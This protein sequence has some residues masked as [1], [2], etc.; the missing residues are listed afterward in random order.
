MDGWVHRLWTQKKVRFKTQVKAKGEDEG[1]AA[2]TGR[3]Q[4]Q[5]EKQGSEG[6]SQDAAA[7]EAAPETE[8]EE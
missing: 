6:E 3:K 1:G 5:E 7:A 8:Q 2:R 4:A